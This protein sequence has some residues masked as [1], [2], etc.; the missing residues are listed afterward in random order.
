MHLS[1]CQNLL[2]GVAGKCIALDLWCPKETVRRQSTLI[3]LY[4]EWSDVEGSRGSPGRLLQ[5]DAL[6]ILVSILSS[7][8]MLF[9]DEEESCFS[10]CRSSCP[11]PRLVL[12]RKRFFLITFISW[13]K[14]L[15]DVAIMK[16][17]SVDDCLT[18]AALNVR[19]K[20]MGAFHHKSYWFTA[21]CHQI[22]S[23][24][25][26]RSPLRWY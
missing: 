14:E 9:L 13:P 25:A 17:T 6:L 24:S 11:V 18:Q 3:I 19:S 7:D 10:G 16:D 15:T 20:L 22:C 8:G 21:P 2:E 12:K 5:L 4:L 1:V 23:F 26:Q